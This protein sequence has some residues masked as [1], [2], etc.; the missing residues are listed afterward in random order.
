M[1]FHMALMTLV[2]LCIGLGPSSSWLTEAQGQPPLPVPPLPVPPPPEA[3]LGRPEL[4]LPAASQT[5]VRVLTTA[6]AAE[7]RLVLTASGEGAV[8]MG[9]DVSSESQ[10]WVLGPIGRDLYRLQ[11]LVGDRLW[12]LSARGPAGA[13]V[14][15]PTSRDS[16]QLWRLVPSLATDRAVRLESVAYPGRSL[17]GSRDTLVTLERTSGGPAQDWLLEARAVPP[18]L[19]LP[20]VRM[21]EHALRPKSALPP[22]TATLL[23]SHDEELWVV[24]RDLR[25]LHHPAGGPDLSG[26]FGRPLR[27]RPGAAVEV[28]LERD[29]GATL[30]ETYEVVS[31][32]G[33]FYRE[34]L[35]TALPPAQLY[36]IAVYERFLQS[37]AIDRT[38]KSP[39]PIEDVNYQPKG[40]GIFPIPPGNQ[41]SGGVVDVYR[42]AKQANNP[43]GV[44]HLVPVDPPPSET[45]RDPLRE[46]LREFQP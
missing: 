30:V 4:G 42:L 20:R 19:D 7:R 13:A 8:R 15:V 10:F 34:E 38:G 46:L 3:D 39:N 5:E 14:L 6:D 33:G 26:T 2:G 37:I 45:S 27:I 36:D 21:T 28:E 44:P 24:I 29:P 40:L 11:S 23:N 32:F 9:P 41:F 31:P 43:G 16:Q 35:V 25:G 1:H 22:V 12:S 18:R 17:A